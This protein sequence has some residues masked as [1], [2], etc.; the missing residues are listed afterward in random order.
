MFDYSKA[1]HAACTTMGDPSLWWAGRLGG[2]Q[3]PAPWGRLSTPTPRPSHAHLPTQREEASQLK[4]KAHAVCLHT[5][6]ETGTSDPYSKPATS[7]NFH[8][9]IIREGMW[10]RRWRWWT[11]PMLR[12]TLEGLEGKVIPG[13]AGRAGT[14]FSLL[15][16][17]PRLAEERE[18]GK[19][20]A[21]RQAW[22]SLV[23]GGREGIFLPEFCK[24][25]CMAGRANVVERARP[26]L[27]I[28]PLGRLLNSWGRRKRTDL[29]DCLYIYVFYVF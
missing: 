24:K 26:H 28:L 11:P 8:L 19:G 2:G 16:L 4:E 22:K 6:R 25:A 13:L 20:G 17:L 3:T 21:L 9:I 7:Y 15:L 27:P 1:G 12:E 10:K 5:W 14:F 23:M 18:A 29:C